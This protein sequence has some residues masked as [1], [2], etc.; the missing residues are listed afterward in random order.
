[1]TDSVPAPQAI[2]A[3]LEE[4]VFG[5][6]LAV[7]E[8]AVALAK[9]LAGL[10]AGNVLLIGPSGTG[11]TTVMRAVES[12]LASSPDLARRSTLIRVHAN[13]LAQEADEG[14]PGERLLHRLLARARE[15]LGEKTAGATDSPADDIE[16]LLPDVTDV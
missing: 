4:R 11:K 6:R 10:A 7:R 2:A 15:Q 8:I 5:Q 3:A 16:R 1:M 9:K 13:I 12:F 14:A